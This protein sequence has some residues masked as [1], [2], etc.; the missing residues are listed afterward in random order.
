MDDRIEA[1]FDDVTNRGPG[2]HILTGP[3]AVTGARPGDTLEVRILSLEPR[4][5]YGSNLAGH[6]GQ[7]YPDFG[8]E[9]V[10]V[11]RLDLAAGL[12]RAAFA[13]DWIT[14]PLVDSPGTVVEAGSV[15]REP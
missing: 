10:T 4:L 13:Y 15:S 2:P 12:A 5:P 7:L 14:T 8:K 6:W 11:Y 3:I 1:I 9:R